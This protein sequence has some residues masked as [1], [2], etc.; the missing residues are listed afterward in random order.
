MTTKKSNKTVNTKAHLKTI[1]IMV[2]LLGFMGSILTWPQVMLK[3]MVAGT[4]IAFLALIY[5]VIYSTVKTRDL[6]NRD[7][8]EHG[9]YR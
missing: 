7:K 9:D 8:N 4:G 6:D 2:G 1:G 3:V 5:Y